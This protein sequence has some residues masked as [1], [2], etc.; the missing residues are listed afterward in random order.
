MHFFVTE[1]N[2]TELLQELR[3]YEQKFYSTKIQLAFKQESNPSIKNRF[4][5]ERLNYTTALNNL[6]NALLKDIELRRELLE[7]NLKAGLNNLNVAIQKVSNTVQI[8]ETIKTVTGIVDKIV[9]I[10]LRGLT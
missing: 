1:Q 2:R 9:G 7:P 4:G 6:E 5:Q 3:E 10:A 8:L